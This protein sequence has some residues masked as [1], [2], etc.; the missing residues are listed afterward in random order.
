M[1]IRAIDTFRGLS[2]VLMVFFTLTLRLSD[3]LPDAL[4]H[5]AEESLHIGDFVLPMFL[6]ASGMSMVFFARKRSRMKKSEYALDALERFGK[7][8][9]I[10]VFLTPFSAGG[11]LHMD[12]VMLNAVLFLPAIILLGF[13]EVALAAVAVASVLLYLGLQN[14]AMLP[15]FTEYY[16]GG[17][18]AAAFYLPVMLAGAIAG[19]N[20]EHLEKILG[21]ALIAAVLLLFVVPPHKMSASP[22]FMALSVVFSL[23]VFSLVKNFKSGSLEYL[24]RKPIRYWVLMF[25]VLLIPLGIYAEVAGW[26]APL[27]LG[28]PLAV[29]VS[30]LCLPILFLLSKALDKLTGQ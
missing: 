13:S 2:I 20:L 23:A 6:F 8:V 17:Y 27:H 5:N 11:F 28:W 25:A 18:P 3:S 16:L 29:V 24:G 26:G 1:R 14:F 7:L 19:R 21:A 4:V 22:S 10:S 30:L 9:L 15:D 12:E